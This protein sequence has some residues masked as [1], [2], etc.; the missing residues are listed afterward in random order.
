MVDIKYAN[1]YSEVLEILK[2]IPV[3]DY[4]KIPKTKIKLFKTNANNDYSFN[5]NPGKT[6]EEQEVSRI[7]KGII[8]IL[9]R[10][11][12]AT[13]I[14]R[15]KIISKQK[16]DRIK[17]EEEKR[18]QYNTNIFQDRNNHR[19]EQNVVEEFSTNVVAMIEYKEPVFRKIINKIKG[20]FHR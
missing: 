15:E 3:E 17:I 5:Y 12:W 19:Q 16:Y 10:D 20:I 7:T 1:A 9:F 6:L 13:E 4:N 11:Y 14:Q 18:T 8:A 2:Y